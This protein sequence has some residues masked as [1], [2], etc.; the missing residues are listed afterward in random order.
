VVD[1]EL[2]VAW[3]TQPSFD[4][5][6]LSVGADVGDAS[7]IPG[8]K[9][10]WRI[11]LTRKYYYELDARSCGAEATF[12]TIQGGGDRD[13]ETSRAAAARG[14]PNRP[15]DTFDFDVYRDTTKPTD[16]SSSAVTLYKQ[17]SSSYLAAAP[18]PTITLESNIPG[19]KAEWRIDFTM[20]YNY[21]LLARSSGVEDTYL[22]ISWEVN[23]GVGTSGVAILRDAS[24]QQAAV[25]CRARQT[26]SAGDVPPRIG[27]ECLRGA[28]SPVGGRDL[29][30]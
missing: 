15:A 30:R 11:D 17:F 12:S 2:A 23:A 9:P 10:E 29:D 19:Y 26:R 28:A 22:N 27:R 3:G 14:D 1:G 25:P 7:D 6:E 20:E 4:T 5:F 13:V 16:V 8:Y 24:N 18:T 21:Y